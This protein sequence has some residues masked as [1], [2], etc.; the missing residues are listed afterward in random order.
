MGIAQIQRTVPITGAQE[1]TQGARHIEAA[2]GHLDSP[3]SAILG[4]KRLNI[5]DMMP[6]SN[7]LVFTVTLLTPA[8]E[9]QE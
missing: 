4:N 3:A 1:A 5:L 6:F 9:P 7:E 8:E 2:V